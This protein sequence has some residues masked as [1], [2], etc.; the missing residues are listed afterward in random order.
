MRQLYQ[1]PVS[2]PFLAFAIVSVFGCC[3]CDGSPGGAVSGWLFLQSLLHTSCATVYWRLSLEITG[4]PGDKGSGKRERA[5]A[6]R[7]NCLCSLP[8]AAGFTSVS[9]VASTLPCAESGQAGP[10][11]GQ[12]ASK[13]C[14]GASSGIFREHTT[15]QVTVLQ[16]L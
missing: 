12:L 10:M 5:Q 6:G 15:S 3:I 8:A 9:T 13:E 14:R 2:K 7:R 11:R 16:L 4:L 1:V